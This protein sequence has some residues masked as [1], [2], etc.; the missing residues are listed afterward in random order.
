MDGGSVWLTIQKQTF[1]RARVDK[2]ILNKNKL[3]IY[4]YGKNL[5]SE[6]KKPYIRLCIE[7]PR[8]IFEY[9]MTM[10]T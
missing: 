2:H 9:S 5:F 10:R 3:Q 6:K 8:I 7:K 1:G 4:K